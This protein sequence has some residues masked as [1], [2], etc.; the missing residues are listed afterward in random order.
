[1][2]VLIAEDEPTLAG[3]LKSALEK[4]RLVV[5]LAGDGAEAQYLGETD[6]YDMIILDM[7]L[8]VRDGLSVL[9]AWRGSG[10]DCPV[11][12]L[13]A[14]NDWSARVDGLDAGADDCL[15]K[16]FHMA[17]LSARVRAMIRRKAGQANP[18]FTRDDVTFDT[19]TTQVMRG[20]LPVRLT[21]QEIAV[22]SY[23]FHNAGRLVSGDELAQHIYHHRADRES[24]TVAV[25][26]NR[27]RK[28]LG[29]GLIVTVRGRGYMIKASA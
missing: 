18:V 12:L 22:L 16:P 14:A 6:P 11:L 21:A 19:R 23:L 3:Q 1:M 20:G 15:P 5:D 27:L 2:R 9:K 26:I 24:N 17:E 4:E 7:A 25:F 28:K 8:S 29:K 13:T 10:M